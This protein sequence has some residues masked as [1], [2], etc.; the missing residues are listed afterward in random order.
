MSKIKKLL[1]QVQRHPN[2]NTVT[3]H[4]NKLFTK[5]DEGLGGD[6]CDKELTPLMTQV[7]S[8]NGVVSLYAKGFEFR[9]TKGKV[10]EWEPLIKDIIL[11]IRRD[12]GI[13]RKYEILNEII[14]Y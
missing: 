7:K 10:F 5:L 4:S 11:L 13:R 6:W 14:A 3:F 2:V 1:I 9:V 12:H 8:L